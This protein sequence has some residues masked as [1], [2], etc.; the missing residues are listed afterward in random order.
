MYGY[1]I[2][3]IDHCRPEFELNRFIFATLS[4][5]AQHR[6][7]RKFMEINPQSSRS[8]GD[9][10]EDL[11]TLPNDAFKLQKRTGATAKLATGI[12]R[13][14]LIKDQASAEPIHPIVWKHLRQLQLDLEFSELETEIIMFFFCKTSSEDFTEFV[15]GFLPGRDLTNLIALCLGRKFLDIATALKDDQKLLNMGILEPSKFITRGISLHDQVFLYLSGVGSKSILNKY[16]RRDTGKTF[17]LSSFPVPE[18]RRRL[19]QDILQSPGRSNI[20]LYGH[21]GTGKSEFARSLARSLNQHLFIVNQVPDESNR[22]AALLVTAKHASKTKKQALILFDEADDFLNTMVLLFPQKDQPN[23]GILNDLID[24]SDAKIIWISNRIDEIDS[25]VRRRFDYNI[26]FRPFNRHE[27]LLMWQRKLRGH[28]LKKSIAPA[29]V[30]YL[31]GE[32]QIDAAG[33]SLVLEQTQRFT[34]ASGNRHQPE[35][36]ETLREIAR[37]HESLM[38]G[39]K[40]PAY[41]R[42]RQDIYDPAFLNLDMPLDRIIKSLDQHFTQDDQNRQT[43]TFL[44]SGPP[45]TGKSEFAQYLA[46]YAKKDFCIK[47]ASDL[48]GPYVGQTEALITEVFNN[49]QRSDSILIVDEIDSFLSARNEYQPRWQ[50]SMTNEF[51]SCIDRFQGVFIA[52]T[53]IL[54]TL[55]LAAIR[56]FQWKITFRHL[57]QK[58]RIEMF[59]AN[60]KKFMNGPLPADIQTSL[61]R[62]E[63]L[64]PADFGIVLRKLTWRDKQSISLQ[65]ILTDLEIELNSRSLNHPIGFR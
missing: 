22:R 47:R 37:Q 2:N 38:T 35:I 45:G 8:R 4:M 54:N 55:D 23:K 11:D 12:I 20:L 14:A 48:L 15:D 50:N 31:A 30:E 43:L 46:R 53:N 7:T 34:S 39:R 60:F 10:F 5:Q 13:D 27:R 9:R 57:T 41:N 3:L 56:R 16:Y 21:P 52:T 58:S 36:E 33:I 18:K 24:R 42:R 61:H 40:A 17:L 51:L 1:L 64:T 59:R 62:M 44:F 32:H 19:L 63:G 65:E 6:I 28:P 29:T 26:E 25:S 49:A